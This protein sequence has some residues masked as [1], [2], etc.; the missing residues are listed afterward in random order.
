M[1]YRLMREPLIARTPHGPVRRYRLSTS[2]G[3]LRLLFIIDVKTC[4][5]IFTDVD[6][7]DEEKPIRG[8]KEGYGKT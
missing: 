1:I 2:S 7:R 3:W 6:V 8:S 4:I 5:I